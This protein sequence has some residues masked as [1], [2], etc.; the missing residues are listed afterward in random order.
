MARKRNEARS[1]STEGGAA[2]PP[3]RR[4][5]SARPKPA[6]DAEAAPGNA[7]PAPDAAAAA[8]HAI[9]EVREAPVVDSPAAA[10]DYA[11]AAP[12]YAEPQRSD[13]PASDDSEIARLAYS[14]WEARRGQGGSAEE[15]WLRAEQEYRRRRLSEGR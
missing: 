11:A 5:R 13:V 7:P 10:G 9:E 4:S 8:P 6:P 3:L 2:A 15:D 12:S 1:F 14:Y